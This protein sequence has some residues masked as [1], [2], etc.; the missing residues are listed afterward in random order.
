MIALKEH[1]P[2]IRI[3]EQPASPLRFRYACEGSAGSIYGV[4]S[5]PDK[6]TYPRIEVVGFRGKAVAIVSCVTTEL[7]HRYV[8]F[9]F[10]SIYH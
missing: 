3:T 4:S 8:L 9:Q 6:K 7:P 10:D 5:T 2:Y 1:K